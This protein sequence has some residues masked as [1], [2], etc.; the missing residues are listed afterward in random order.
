MKKTPLAREALRDISLTIDDGEFIGLIGRTGS[1][2]STLIQHLNGLLKPDCGS[3]VVDGVDT[4]AGSLRLLR[5]KVGLV[6][7]FPEYQLFEETVYK[8]IAYGISKR[9]YDAA[10]IGDRVYKAARAVGIPESIMQKSPFELSG[11]QRRRVAIAGVLVMEPKYLVMDEPGSGLDPEGREEIFSYVKRL[12]DD[13]GTSIILVSHNMADIAKLVS[14]VI[15]L[16]D[17]R[18]VMDGFPEEIFPKI[19]ELERA[20]L[21]SPDIQ[22][23]FRRLKAIVPQIDDKAITARQAADELEK[24]LRISVSA[25]KDSSKAPSSADSFVAHASTDS[26]MEPA[27]KD[28]SETPT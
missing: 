26:S 7:Q 23:L 12:R 18:V 4:K 28:S 6:F 1:G 15:A 10:E 2:K 14:R 3:V 8:D 19:D 25:S 16:D 11:G 22:Y 27:S 9:G 17:G 13:Y 5:Q 21:R 24:W 20:G